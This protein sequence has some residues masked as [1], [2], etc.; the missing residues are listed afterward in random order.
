MKTST[1]KASRI[2]STGRKVVM[3]LAIASMFSGLSV[4]T[5]FADDGRDWHDRQG[6]HGQRQWHGNYNQRHWRGDREGDGYRQE[7]RHPYTY[8]QP[9]YVPPPDYYE[10]RQSPGISLFFPLDLRR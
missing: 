8:A 3:A 1:R 6:D 2:G 4:S 9:V 5:A 10:P 7:Y